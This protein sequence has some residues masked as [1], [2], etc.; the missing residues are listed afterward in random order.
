MNKFKLAYIFLD[1]F[2][3]CSMTGCMSYA[4]YKS[5]NN[6]A[7]TI[8]ANDGGA[9][10]GVNVNALDLLKDR[11]FET[12]LSAIV[13]GAMAYG[14]YYLTQDDNSST[15]NSQDVNISVT[16]NENTIN[17]GSTLTEDIDVNKE[18]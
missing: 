13:D 14:V 17:Y 7:M 18:D 1:I 15:K 12:I 6:N 2:F 4:N 8:R 11:P 10:I 9:E 16:G 5:Y 3:I